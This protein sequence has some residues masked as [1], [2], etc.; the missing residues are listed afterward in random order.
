MSRFARS[1]AS[2]CFGPR[3]PMKKSPIG[4]RLTVLLIAA[5]ASGCMAS[6]SPMQKRQITTKEIDGSYDDAFRATLTVLQDQGY[7]IRHTDMETGLISAF[8]SREGGFLSTTRTSLEMSCIVTEVAEERSRLRMTLRE[9][10]SSRGH[11]SLLESLFAPDKEREV[12]DPDV[13]Q[14][15]FNQ[16]LVEVRRRQAAR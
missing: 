3:D 1:G 16:I 11:K 14:E 9:R 15:L 8:T 4:R 2:R 13:Y 12:S 5:V 6:L 10:K 7:A